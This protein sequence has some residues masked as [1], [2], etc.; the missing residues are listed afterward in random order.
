M[1]FINDIWHYHCFYLSNKLFMAANHLRN[2]LNKPSRKAV[3]VV[4]FTLSV[5]GG[6]LLIGIPGAVLVGAADWLLLMTGVGVVEL[7]G[8]NVWPT[9]ILI[10]LLWPFLMVPVSKLMQRKV[11]LLHIGFHWLAII[12]IS[13][14]ITVLS[15]YIWFVLSAA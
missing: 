6:F 10:S 13:L 8:D 7:S 15:I 3:W 4:C 12:L 5:I 9:V 1:I 14:V 11:P 2:E